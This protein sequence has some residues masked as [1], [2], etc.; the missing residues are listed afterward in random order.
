MKTIINYL[1]SIILA[2]MFIVLIIVNLVSSTILNE[3][4]ILNEL[5]KSD[6]YSKI[7]ELANSNFEKYI[8][9]S[10]LDE[11]VLV[12]IVSKEKIKKD[13]EIIIENINDRYI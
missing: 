10:G 9:Q 5:E 4:Y 2:I 8:Y 3:K 1:L 11:K 6:Y 13:T 12:G 7:L